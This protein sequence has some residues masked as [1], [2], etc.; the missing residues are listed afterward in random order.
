MDQK[1]D[2]VFVS[3]VR[4]H[5]L[6]ALRSSQ[7]SIVNSVVRTRILN[8]GSVCTKWRANSA[9]SSDVRR[10]DEDQSLR[11]VHSGRRRVRLALRLPERHAAGVELWRTVALDGSRLLT[12]GLAGGARLLIPSNAATVDSTAY[13]HRWGCDVLREDTTEGGARRASQDRRHGCPKHA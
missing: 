3:S 9:R 7:N 5:G 12:R 2:S 13:S 11:Q 4:N 8:P 10:S 6:F 1:P